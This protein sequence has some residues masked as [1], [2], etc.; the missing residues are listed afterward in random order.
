MAKIMERIKAT[1]KSG[2]YFHDASLMPRRGV[3]DLPTLLRSP[4]SVTNARPLDP[5]LP[6]PFAFRGRCAVWWIR[7]VGVV[8]VVTCLFEVEQRLE[9]DI[10]NVPLACPAKTT[11]IIS[12]DSTI[13]CLVFTLYL[14]LASHFIIAP[15]I[16]SFPDHKRESWVYFFLS[17]RFEGLI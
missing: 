13:T 1:D 11:T 10:F 7:G 16:F 4:S 17:S 3:T 2:I 9:L 5:L 14:F 12:D 8:V 15:T 6:L